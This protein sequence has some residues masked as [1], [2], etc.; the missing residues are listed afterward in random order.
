MNLNRSRSSKS[1]HSNYAYRSPAPQS[2]TAALEM[3]ALS[4][5]ASSSSPSPHRPSPVDRSPSQELSRNNQ[6]TQIPSTGTSPT[7]PASPIQFQEPL[8]VS[9]DPSSLGRPSTSAS[10]D[11]AG[12]IGLGLSPTSPSK[13]KKG[14]GAGMRNASEPSPVVLRGKEISAPTLNAGMC[15]SYVLCMCGLGGSLH[16]RV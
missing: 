12:S 1:T 16:G 7:S 2:L 5:P 6:F 15:F 8:R 11:R 14:L 9:L 10:R 3:I 4:P 13:G